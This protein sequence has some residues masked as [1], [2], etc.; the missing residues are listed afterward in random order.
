VNGAAFTT[1]TRSHYGA[2]VTVN[3]DGSWSYDPTTSAAIQKLTSG[4]ESVVDY[5][6]YAVKDPHGT[7]IDPQVNIVVAGGA[8]PYRYD[9]VANTA[10]GAYTSL[11]VGP[12]VNNLGNVAFRASAT[13]ISGRRARAA[14]VNNRRFLF[15][16]PAS[17]P[18]RPRRV[19]GRSPS[20]SSANTCKSTT[21]IT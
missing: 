17:F 16:A 8:S 2:A 6:E 20:S 19:R 9:I 18:W 3:P 21:P 10:N 7:V 5:F 14:A 15:S 1:T 13:F 11:G 4:G 12:S